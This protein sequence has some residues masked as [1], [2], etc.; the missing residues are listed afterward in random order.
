MPRNDIYYSDK[1]YD[2]SYEYRH[3]HLPKDLATKVP[4]DKLMSEA[5]WRALGVCQ[6]QGI[7][8]T[9][10]IFVCTN[11][12]QGS[13]GGLCTPTPIECINSLFLYTE[14]ATHTSRA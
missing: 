1:Y 12:A 10:S 8:I 9:K 11:V 2:D 3:V 4:K 7:L 5:E 6:S 14:A 13:E